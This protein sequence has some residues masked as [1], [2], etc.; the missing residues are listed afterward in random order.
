MFAL[1][2][3][4][5]EDLCASYVDISQA[6]VVAASHDRAFLTLLRHHSLGVSGSSTLQRDFLFSSLTHPRT[7][8]P[9]IAHSYSH[10]PQP[11]SLSAEMSS[12]TRASRGTPTSRK[13]PSRGDVVHPASGRRG[14]SPR[15]LIIGEA[16]L[17]RR[18]E[19][20][21]TPSQEPIAAQ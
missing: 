6:S 4:C 16:P 5:V 14:T 19:K 20:H 21:L 18:P 8:S 11:P 1:V 3:A 17:S 15:D 10:I 9:L 12:P 13:P 7:H 2:A